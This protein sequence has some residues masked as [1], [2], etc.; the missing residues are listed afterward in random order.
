MDLGLKDSRALVTGASAGIG[1]AVAEALAAEG[2]DLFLSGRD[3]ER[4]R[5]VAERARA[6][7]GVA[8]EFAAFDLSTSKDQAELASAAVDV[9]ILV[10]NAGSNPAGGIESI[11]EE[12]WRSSWDLKVFGYI[13]LTRRYFRKMKARRRGVI[14]NV[15]GN[16]GERMNADYILGSSGNLALMGL[17]RALGGR[18]PDSGVRVVGVNPGATNTSRAA[19]LLRRWSEDRF[20]DPDRTEEIL[21]GLNLP[22]GRMAEP[23]EV[24]DAVVFL[25]SARA[26][27]ISATVVTVD[28]GAASRS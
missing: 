21:A 1:A 25:A 8:I 24:A 20:G 12:L 5:S 16:S 13:N 19:S 6:T 3:G 4:L 22:F 15:I 18:S 7:H 14:V 23:G 26:A 10:N 9:D 28:G 17:A 27:Y 11:T 2:C